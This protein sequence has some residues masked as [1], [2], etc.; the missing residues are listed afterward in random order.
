MC[1]WGTRPSKLRSGQPGATGGR[2]RVQQPG[3]LPTVSTSQHDEGHGVLRQILSN[4]TSGLRS[5]GQQPAIAAGG[6]KTQLT[7]SSGPTNCPPPPARSELFIRQQLTHVRLDRQRLQS[8]SPEPLRQLTAATHVYLHHN[9]LSSDALPLLASALPGLRFL[10]LSHNA[11][12]KVRS[13]PRLSL[14][15]GFRT[16][17]QG[18]SHLQALLMFATLGHTC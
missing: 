10:A 3:P 6:R 13:T 17:R 4:L 18:A 15:H 8:V 9:R 16:E 12:D 1:I 14:A 7:Q 11:I 2:T 5:T